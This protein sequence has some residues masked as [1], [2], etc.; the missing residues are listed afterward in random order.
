VNASAPATENAA[1]ESPADGVVNIAAYRFVALYGL[2]RRRAGLR[3]LCAE[4]DLRG[5]ILLSP[6]GINLVLAGSREGI[7]RFLDHLEQDADLAGM[8]VKRSL[9][10]TQPFARMKI[11]LKREIIAFDIEGVDPSVETS[12][13]IAAKTLRQWLSEG[14]NVTLLDVRNEYEIAHGTFV[15][16]HSLGLD[17]F[18]ELPQAVDR[19]DEDIRQR[20]LVM[21]CTGGIRCEKA[22]PYLQR[23]GFREVYQLEGGILQYFAACGGDHY[24]GDCF[25]FDE[26]VAVDHHLRPVAGK[27]GASA[28]GSST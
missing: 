4:L 1:V 12:P 20:P 16:A 28:S 24:E 26:R 7:E 19:L 2:E 22:G 15:G 9:S 13:I 8:T 21:F 18:R 25:V 11:K 14:R 5:T 27:L 10:T 6:E 3:R 17:H 23:Q